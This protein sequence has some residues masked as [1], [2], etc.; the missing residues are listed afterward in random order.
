M[1]T[2]E[3]NII[4]DIETV[5]NS[6]EKNML[7]LARTKEA[8]AALV[9][10]NGYFGTEEIQ[11]VILCAAIGFYFEESGDVLEYR[12][13]ARF[14]DVSIMQLLLN[15]GDIE[16]LKSRQYLLNAES[17]RPLRMRFSQ[18]QDR[19][20]LKVNRNLIQS[21]LEN[22]E[23][24]LSDDEPEIDEIEFIVKVAEK[25]E[26]RESIGQNTADLLK[27][28]SEFE[29]RHP[30]IPF[31]KDTSA[32][33]DR[34]EDRILF[35]SVCRDFLK[36]RSTG[37]ETL[38]SDIYDSGRGLR[39]TKRLLEGSHPLINAA[40]VEFD[41]KGSISRAS[42]TLASAGQKLF[43]K[44]NSYLFDAPIND[45]NFISAEK[46]E[47]KKLLFNKGFTER[48]DELKRF[49]E[50]SK[51]CEIQDRL[52]KKKM[53]PGLTVLFYGESGTGKT[54]TVYQL[55][56]ASGRG[57]YHVDIASLKSAWF[58]DSEKALR[59]VFAKYRAACDQEKKSGHPIPVLLFNEADAFFRTRTINDTRNMSRTEN[60]MQNILL[61]E[62]EK[63]DGILI[64][65]TNLPECMDSA[66]SRRFTFKLEFEIPDSETSANIWKDK[67]EWLSDS[68]ADR[69]SRNYAFSGGFIDNVCK[70]ATMFETLYNRLPSQERMDLYCSEETALQKSFLSTSK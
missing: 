53:N 50:E 8:D 51:F 10:L 38:F 55:A 12:N 13:L 16:V 29:G 70:K 41:R 45:E 20:L 15:N 39:E 9:R 66:F 21:I 54:E 33:L 58:G 1:K 24:S 42:I 11:T 47:E 2:M 44:D 52:R 57:V 37:L 3:F 25:V 27:E 61:E 7:S 17:T 14:F 56:K 43:L 49:L 31:I 40:L 36:G 26:E 30:E 64:A 4:K 63:I 48:I 60:S 65:A 67:L 69:L 5:R 35:Y 23:I 59:K 18:R 19:M 46:I 62:L 32:I 6:A 22:R 34:I 68:Q 28:L